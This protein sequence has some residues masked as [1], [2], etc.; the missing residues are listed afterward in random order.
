[1]PKPLEQSD[2]AAQIINADVPGKVWLTSF[3]L[4]YVFSQLLLSELVSS[5]C[6]FSIVCGKSTDTYRFKTEFYGLTDMPKKFQKAMD[7]TL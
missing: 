5:H 1:M 6:N 3:D 4:K 2:V 7:N